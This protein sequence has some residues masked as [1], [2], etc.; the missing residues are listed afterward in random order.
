MRNTDVLDLFDK[1]SEEY[2]FIKSARNA[3]KGSESF[4]EGRMVYSKV[5]VDFIIEEYERKIAINY[6]FKNEKFK[7]IE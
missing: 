2:K 4:S 6:L 3:L 1:N 5:I 7:G